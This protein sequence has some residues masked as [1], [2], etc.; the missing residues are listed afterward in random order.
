[1]IIHYYDS[2]GHDKMVEVTALKQIQTDEHN[3]HPCIKNMKRANDAHPERLG[4]FATIEARDRE[5][6]DIK[7]AFESGCEEYTVKNS[8]T[9][10]HKPTDYVMFGKKEGMKL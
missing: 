8:I 10:G 5:L 3:G 6:E 1:M 7:V 9:E 2:W 4:L